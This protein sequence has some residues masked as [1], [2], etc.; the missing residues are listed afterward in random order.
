[1]KRGINF[2]LFNYVEMLFDSV[3]N[4]LKGWT[5]QSNNRNLLKSRFLTENCIVY[6]LTKITKRLDAVFKLLFRKQNFVELVINL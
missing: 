4:V 1:M 3:E 5:K 2:C 6:T